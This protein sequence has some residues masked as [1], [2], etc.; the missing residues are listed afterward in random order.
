[1]LIKT[2]GNTAHL[3]PSDLSKL[4]EDIND[5]QEVQLNLHDLPQEVIRQELQNA[6]VRTHALSKFSLAQSMQDLFG[7]WKC[8]SL[9]PRFV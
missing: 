7:Y 8:A 9:P 4:R 2:E 5:E 6:G 1:M 3:M